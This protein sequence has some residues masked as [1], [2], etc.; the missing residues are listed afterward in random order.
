[1]T[2]SNLREHRSVLQ[3]LYFHRTGLRIHAYIC[4]VMVYTDSYKSFNSVVLQNVFFL[5]CEGH[6]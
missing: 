4:V 6:G 5:S 3:R 2:K 1:M